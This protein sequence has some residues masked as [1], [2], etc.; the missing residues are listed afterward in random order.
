MQSIY[1]NQSIDASLVSGPAVPY[2][3]RTP[4]TA[5]MFLLAIKW[6]LYSR[7]QNYSRIS[8]AHRTAQPSFAPNHRVIRRMG[9]NPDLS[10]IRQIQRP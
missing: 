9:D 10:A 8:S 5:I 2:G 1:S 6:K 7:L 4:T 3:A